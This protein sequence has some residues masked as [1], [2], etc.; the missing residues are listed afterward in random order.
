ML[1]LLGL[2]NASAQVN[3]AVAYYALD[4]SSDWVVDSSGFGGNGTAVGTLKRGETGATCLLDDCFF[5]HGTT[6][7][8]DLSFNR[9]VSTADSLTLTYWVKTNT[10][11][12]DMVIGKT[13]T[14]NNYIVNGINYRQVNRASM[15]TEIGSGGIRDY[16]SESSTALINDN[17]WHFVAMVWQPGKVSVFNATVQQANWSVQFYIDGAFR[18]TTKF[19]EVSNSTTTIVTAGNW[20]IGYMKVL[21]SPGTNYT[22]YLDELAIYNRTLNITELDTLY[23]NGNGFNPYKAPPAGNFTITAINRYNDTLI[24]DFN[25]TVNGTLFESVAGVATTNINATVGALVN[26]TVESSTYHTITTNGINVSI[27]SHQSKM[28]QH[29][30]SISAFSNSSGNSIQI[31]NVFTPLKT[32]S[33]TNGTLMAFMN[34]GNISANATATGFN[35][36][37]FNITTGEVTTGSTN[38]FMNPNISFLLKNEVTGG[39]FNTSLADDVFLEIF[40]PT[41][42]FT[43]NFTAAVSNNVTIEVDCGWTLMKLDLEFGNT[44]YFR[45]LVPD[46]DS[47]GVDFWVVDL[48][49][50][51]VVQTNIIINDLTGDFTGGQ[52]FMNRFVNGSDEQIAGGVFDVENKIVFFLLK[53]GLYTLTIVSGDSTQT[54]VIGQILADAASTKTINIPDI[55]LLPNS[56]LGGTVQWTLLDLG[57]DIKFFYNDSET[58]TSTLRFAITNGTGSEVF[59]ATGGVLGNFF[60]KFTIVNNETTH[61]ACFNATHATFGNI[62]E[63]TVFGP[64]GI[65]LGPDKF[66]GFTQAGLDQFFKWTG[67]P[68]ILFTY[69]G[70]SGGSVPIA[71]TLVAV[72]LAGFDTLGFFSLGGLMG[73]SGSA[74]ATFNGLIL[75]LVALG[76]LLLFLRESEVTV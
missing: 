20:S 42:T 68:I 75:G 63:C 43:H 16:Y 45:T 29:N 23:N 14:G 39:M 59:V 74:E 56:T 38:I 34:G 76:A 21:L 8:V 5:F 31:F 64:S 69:M 19:R 10:T 51:S 22:G 33:A 57:T 40:C 35:P 17:D 24:Q 41:K 11:G 13:E 66:P 60:A 4:E 2:P 67:A 54:R 32:F 26:I 65:F 30:E 49:S 18:G 6:D 12:V 1:V 62:Q 50:D 36:A 46:L 53:N 61:T 72:E 15:T 48:N 9:S 70:A 7:G 28:F 55:L 3:D 25:A 71:L 58:L 47:S 52:G 44:T 27:G 73:L 37:L